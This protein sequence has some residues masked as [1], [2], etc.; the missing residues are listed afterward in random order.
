MASRKKVW[1]EY[2][3]NLRF[4]AL[5]LRKSYEGNPVLR[6]CSFGFEKSGIYI[7]MGPNG[8]G[9]STFLRICALLEAPEE[10]EVIYFSEGQT[11]RK[12]IGLMRRVTLVL[13]EVGIFNA[14]VFRNTAFGLII[15][16]LRKKE[17]EE[18]VQ[19]VLEFVG[20]Q[21]K[22]GHNALT[23]SSGEKQRLGLARAMVIEPEILF[24]DEPTASVD[25]KNSEIIEDMILKMKK[26]GTPT[27]I[28]T[29]HDPAQAVRLADRVMVL[30]EG[31]ITPHGG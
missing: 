11:L 26:D 27:V 13:P 28:M 1:Q 4:S 9:K 19:S 15:R 20:L 16:G 21:K 29:T 3:V 25:H 8:S 17:I 14:D 22:A 31:R 23:L 30:R 6:D 18:R 2:H 12:D 10:G 24:M 5:N 7:L